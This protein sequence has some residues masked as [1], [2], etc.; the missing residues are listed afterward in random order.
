MIFYHEVHG[1]FNERLLK[2]KHKQNPNNLTDGWMVLSTDFPAEYNRNYHTVKDNGTIVVDGMAKVDWLVSPKT[3]D[4]LK[5]VRCD[6]VDK[7]LKEKMYKDVVVTFPDG[8]KTIQFRDEF[9][10]SNLS[11][12]TQAAM[13]AVMNS[14]PETIINYRTEDNVTQAVRADQFVAIGN[15]VMAQ[16]QSLVS[17]AWGHKDV[18]RGLTVPED[19]IAYDVTQGW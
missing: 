3:L 17:A 12:V 6:E 13:S 8:E 7:L 1:R 5:E 18:M 14:Q 2:L 19:I 9:D 16:K 4:D 15:S 11:N 10:R